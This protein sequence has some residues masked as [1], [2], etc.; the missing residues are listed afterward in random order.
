MKH[1]LVIVLSVLL[2]ASCEKDAYESG[3]GKYSYI[4]TDFAE[5]HTLATG[6]VD[7]AITDENDSVAFNPNALVSWTSTPDSVYRALVYYY[8]NIE[9]GAT[10]VY[11][12]NQV[13]ITNYRLKSE[14]KNIYTDP[15][16][17]NS[18]WLSN[19]RK[20]LNIGLSV[21]TG[22]QDGLDNKQS[23][24]IMCDSIIN[25]NDGTHDIYLRL[26]HNQNDVPEYY[27]VST[28]LSMPLKGISEGSN[29]HLTVNT[30]KGTVTKELTY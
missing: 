21:K 2:F 30:Y 9:D 20:Y 26:W 15:V 5:V 1:L 19:N 12:I 14:F 27:S 23:V 18:A 29:I 13:L 11:S 3:D 7:Y 28:Y 17:F 8:N 16:T 10:S 22:V 6:V 4:R 25:N 24:D